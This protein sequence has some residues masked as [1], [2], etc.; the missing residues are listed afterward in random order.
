[1][2]ENHMILDAPPKEYVT[3]FEESDCFYLLGSPSTWTN[4]VDVYDLDPKQIQ[5][6]NEVI[7]LRDLKENWD[8]YGSPPLNVETINTSI[9]LIRNVPMEDLPAPHVI[10]TAG[11]GIQFE[12][13]GNRGL[14]IEVTQD[15]KIE[16]L[17]CENEEPV[18]EGSIEKL[19]HLHSLLRW[20]SLA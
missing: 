18:E 16:Y 12:W 13:G 11:G 20:V 15:G 14:E 8:S 6:I 3:T 17:K 2:E 1:M 5:A 7:R 10:P 19:A 4:E 9:A